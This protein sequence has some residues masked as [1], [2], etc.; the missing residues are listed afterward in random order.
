MHKDATSTSN[1]TATPDKKIGNGEPEQR[2]NPSD[3]ANRESRQRR[4]TVC[5][6]NPDH[7]TGEAYAKRERSP[8]TSPA[9]KPRSGA[10]WQRSRS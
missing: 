4:K 1:E 5:R 2:G 10:K 8:D 7:I 6:E 3:N 9:S